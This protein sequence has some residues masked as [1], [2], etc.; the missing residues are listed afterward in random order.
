MIT[1]EYYM[2]D[3]ACSQ[4]KAVLAY[5]QERYESILDPVYISGQEF[6]HF[7]GAKIFVTRHEHDREHGYVFSIFYKG[8]QV[9]YGVFEHCVCDDLC[10]ER[11]EGFNTNIWKDGWKKWDYTKTFPY[12]NIKECGDWIVKDM[13]KFL[14]E[15]KEYEEEKKRLVGCIR[16]AIKDNGPFLFDD[17]TGKVFYPNYFKE[18][19]KEIIVEVYIG[20]DDNVVIGTDCADESGQMQVEY[21]DCDYFSNDEIRE[22]IKLLGIKE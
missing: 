2:Q 15:E 14:N 1:L 20:D 4:A 5:L 17:E 3:G 10:V 7:D 21:T 8:K 22:I 18:P 12:F 16:D 13:Q 6:D 11:T 9:N 19:R